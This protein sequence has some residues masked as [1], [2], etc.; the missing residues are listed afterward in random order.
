MRFRS[1]TGTITEPMRHVKYPNPKFRNATL[2]SPTARLSLIHGMARDLEELV[3]QG[4]RLQ[5]LR[6]DKSITLG[7][8]VS[9][10]TAAR[11]IGVSVRAYRD[12][13][14]GR[15]GINDDNLGSAA[16]YYDTTARWIR[17][18]Q[19]QASVDA[20]DL[21]AQLDTGRGVIAR[22]D[23]NSRRIADNSERLDQL[24][25]TLAT[26]AD[27][28]GRV[29]K[30]IE[31]LVSADVFQAIEASRQASDPNSVPER[32]QRGTTRRRS[33]A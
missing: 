24:D 10:E 2:R 9:Q 22:I 29:S 11:E 1:T 3:A 32:P 28:I 31:Q 30:F 14:T 5:D 23:E 26:L 12:W 18:G 17:Y 27:R 19:A 25:E 7:K 21:V 8:R 6:A 20:P 33:A 4:K 15:G 16:D 13:E